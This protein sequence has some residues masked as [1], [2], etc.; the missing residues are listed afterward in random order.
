MGKLILTE[1]GKTLERVS[2]WIHRNQAYNVTPRHSL[3]YYAEDTGD[4]G[5]VVDFFR[6]NGRKWAVNQFFAFGTMFTPQAGEMWEE[7]DGLHCIAGYDSENWYNP[8]MIELSPD[9]ECVRVYVEV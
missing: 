5:N 9:A 6:W 3:H 4:G 8:I 2:R 1:S 7:S